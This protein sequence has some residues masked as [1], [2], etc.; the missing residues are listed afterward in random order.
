MSS[1][2]LDSVKVLSA[3]IVGAGRSTLIG[4]VKAGGD[5]V[6]TIRLWRPGTAASVTSN[7]TVIL[8]VVLAVLVTLMALGSSEVTV[9]LSKLVP[10]NVIV[11]FASCK[12]VSVAAG[13]SVGGGL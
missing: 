1:F 7:S 13:F 5:G 11:F 12:N 3:A 4:K 10:V 6:R 2:F 9:A 8:L